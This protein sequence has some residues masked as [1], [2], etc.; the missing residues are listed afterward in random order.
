[1]P[2]TLD[3]KREQ[4]VLLPFDFSAASIEALE[5]AR[6]LVA[7]PK[8]LYVLHVVPPLESASPGV[9]LGKLD[10]K[11]LVAHADEALAKQLSTAGI[12][13]AQRRVHVGDPASEIIDV[14][15]EVDAELI[16]IPSKG[17]AGLRR[18]MIGSVAERVVRRAP[19]PV[20]VLP[21]STPAEPTP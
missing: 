15:R 20:L 17:K 11:K 4:I 8:W 2:W 19:C 1:M 5:T 7:G 10:N 14:A 9:V 6:S 18:W 3:D 12:G 16:V 21:I 13:E